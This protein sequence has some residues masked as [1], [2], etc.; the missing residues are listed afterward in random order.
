M[1]DDPGQDAHGIPQKARI[2]RLMYGAFDTGTIGSHDSPLFNALIFGIAQ[3]IAVDQLP[4]LS[5]DPFDVTVESGFLK[6]VF[7]HSDTAKPAQRLRI[8]DM[9]G[10]LFISE[11]EEDFHDSATQNLLSAHSICPTSSR[12]HLAP[13]QVLQ[14]KIVNGMLVV[15]DGADRFQ[16]LALGV[17][18]YVGHQG[19]LILPF[20]AHFTAGSLLAFV[21]ILDCCRFSLYYNK[22]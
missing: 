16:F 4:G 19:H 9:K 5:A 13:V 2:A 20:F 21:V 6:S 17:I 3:D 14:D 1:L 15:N 12:H 11:I 7:G 10:Q 8:N 18:H 22:Q